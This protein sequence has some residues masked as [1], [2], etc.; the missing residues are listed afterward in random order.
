MMMMFSRSLCRLLLV[1][2]L[3]LIQ[4]G[5]VVVVVQAFRPPLVPSSVSTTTTTKARRSSIT[6]RRIRRRFHQVGPLFAIDGTTVPDITMSSN[7]NDVA[8]K[9]SSLKSMDDTAGGTINPI[10]SILQSLFHQSSDT[11]QKIIQQINELFVT[12]NSSSSSVLSLSS[13]DT[14][15]SSLQPMFTQLQQ[16]LVSLGLLSNEDAI[17][18][19][20]AINDDVKD[21]LLLLVNTTPQS[22][23]LGTI[24]S[25]VVISTIV[26]WNQPP[27]LGKPYPKVKYDPLAAKAYFDVRPIEVVGR[28]LTISFKSLSFGLQLLTDKFIGGESVWVQNQEQRGLELAQL[29]TELGPTFIK[30]GQSLSIRTDLLSPGYLRGLSTL[31]D[32]VPAFDTVTAIQILE[33]EWG[34]P[35]NEV[36]DGGLSESATPVAAA[37]L[38]Q[39]YKAKLKESGIEVAI[40]VQRPQITTQIALDM[41][42]L[43]E[44]APIVKKVASLSTDTVGTVDAWGVGFVDELNYIQEAQNGQYFTEQIEK[45]SL[46]N[47]VLAPKVIDEYTSGKVLVTEWVDGERLDRSSQDDVTI[48]CSICMNAYLSMLLEIG[49]LHCD[50]HP[51]NLLRTPD[52]KLCILDWGMVT[53]IPENLQ[54]TLI[55]HMAHLTSGDY[56]EVPRDLFLLG[57]VPADKEDVIE[58][59]GVVEVLADIYGQWTRGGGMAS[60]N[61]NDVFTQIQ[62]LAATR[63]NLFQVPPYFA[64]IAKSFSVLEGIG[65]SN[66]S[67]YSI[68]NECLPYVSN[69][70]LTDQDKMGNALNTFIFGPDKHNLDT[71]LVD[72]NRIEQLVT[73]FGNFTATSASGVLSTPTTTTTSTVNDS[74]NKDVATTTS[75]STTEAAATADDN[76]LD[77]NSIT[78]TSLGMLEKQAD[79]VLDIVLT[80]EETPLQQILIEQL[81]KIL[82]ANTRSLWTEARVRSGVLPTG[83][84]VLGTL[85]DP[86]GLFQTSP[87]VNTCDQDERAVQTTRELIALLRNVGGGGDN[88][89]GGGGGS[90]SGSGI[91]VQSLSNEEQII[92]SRILSQKLWDRR[93]ALIKSSN[94]FV[95]QMLQL[96]STRLESSE[97]VRVGQ[98]TPTIGVSSSSSSTT[99][100]SETATTSTIKSASSS[101]S[102]NINFSKTATTSPRL[103]EARERLD[104]LST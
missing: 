70:L 15:V 21:V 33:A 88:N 92:F 101:S 44:F 26:T 58:D 23:A 100:N 28:S 46:K 77:G 56:E 2:L 19:I 98:R 81:C 41:H 34:C 11:I 51:G 14:I 13:S 89:S 60:I 78:I 102:N 35:I 25:Y 95:N 82:A 47:V 63:G 50:P 16:A 79:Q 96:T 75:L 24:L 40:K 80:E 1:L 32:N 53:R 59:S 42:L 55:E 37:S 99:S 45:T 65:L 90:G 8:S 36:L 7:W 57:F 69:R 73:G 30:I 5:D 71:R 22:I 85:V 18:V 29:L 72:I 83:R 86:F 17:K 49:I 68:I 54:L 76:G 39:V 64:Y 66:D 62:D 38:G 84:T 48:L 67:K 12:I 61:A 104:S 103:Q 87:L 31:Q 52:G 6:T 74:T 94:R 4:D 10:S 91:D 9:L 27:P 3:P 93:S 43:R 20:T 97:R